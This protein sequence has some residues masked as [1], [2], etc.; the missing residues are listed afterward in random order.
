MFTSDDCR[1]NGR[2]WTPIIARTL[3][4][5]AFLLGVVTTINAQ[6]VLV[7][8]MVE[9]GN[10][11]PFGLAAGCS[12]VSPQYQNLPTSPPLNPND[13]AFTMV[14][15]KCKNTIEDWVSNIGTTA[16]IGTVTKTFT[17]SPDSPRTLTVLSANGFTAAP[18][19]SINP[20]KANG[21]ACAPGTG[22]FQPHNVVTCTRS[23]SLAP[24][25]HYPAIIL[26]VLVESFFQAPPVLNIYSA[27]SGGGMSGQNT[28][29]DVVNT[30][31]G[32]SQFC[33]KVKDGGEWT[34][35]GEDMVEL[36]CTDT[37]LTVQ[38]VPPGLGAII[39]GSMIPTPHSFLY[40]V[41]SIHT[42]QEP[43]DLNGLNFVFSS[44]LTTNSPGCV[45]M[46]DT[47]DSPPVWPAAPAPPYTSGNCIFD[48]AG[49]LVI[50]PDFE[51]VSNVPANAPDINQPR[52]LPFTTGSTLKNT[53]VVWVQ[54]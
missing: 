2:G 36:N 41:E 40:F 25:A 33:I 7:E 22:P 13:P 48:G 52:T 26:S 37:R 53:F 4:A 19:S 29:F 1:A 28:A 43:S 46:P 32:P 6:P 24:G 35:V 47:L 44:G 50:R 38:T 30:Y 51:V 23:D 39:D 54:P 45:D 18:G 21:W 10:F 14:S 12:T 42:A 11:N 9:S 8:T 5:S 34:K 15:G 3:L 31:P 49:N 27:V 20:G 17:L 16:T